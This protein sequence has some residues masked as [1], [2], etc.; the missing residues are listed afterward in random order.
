[1]KLCQKPVYLETLS[2]FGPWCNLTQPCT[3]LGCNCALWPFSPQVHIYQ[4]LQCLLLHK[5]ITLS[6]HDFVHL[7]FLLKMLC[8]RHEACVRTSSQHLPDPPPGDVSVNYAFLRP[9]R[10]S[11]FTFVPSRLWG[12][13]AGGV[14]GK[15]H[16]YKSGPV[17]C[18]ESTLWYEMVPSFASVNFPEIDERL[19]GSF[20]TRPSSLFMSM[21]AL[22]CC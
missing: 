3:Y 5:Y 1:M 10:F 11:R 17:H 9:I 22:K 21:M 12:S 16:V 15:T 14:S 19:A 4:C 7:S 18:R 8:I 13:S 6:N 2:T 20:S